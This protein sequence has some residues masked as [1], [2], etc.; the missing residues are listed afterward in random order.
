MLEFRV[1]GISVLL[2]AAAESPLF[3]NG[4]GGCLR[5]P[6]ASISNREGGL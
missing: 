6:V 4:N 2:A 1:P 3:A 5:L